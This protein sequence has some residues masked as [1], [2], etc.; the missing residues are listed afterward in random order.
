M[1]E[2][3]GI[4]ISEILCSYN[5]YYRSVIAF[6][7]SRIISNFDEK[8]EILTKILKKYVKKLSHINLER[9]ALERTNVIELA[10]RVMTGKE[11][12][13]PKE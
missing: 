8:D 4:R 5:A 1:D 11:R 13:P 12:L 2:F 9:E 6:R 7:E 10:I 3:L